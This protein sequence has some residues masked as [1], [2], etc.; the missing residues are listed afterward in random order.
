MSKRRLLILSGFGLFI[1][2]MGM[3]I[4]KIAGAYVI[5]PL[6]VI[7]IALSL[8]GIIDYKISIWL[9]IVIAV[10]LSPVVYIFFVYMM[11]FLVPK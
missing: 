5:I 3:G 8:V 6:Q 7:G 10:I 11:L 9:K 2:A 4:S 1:L